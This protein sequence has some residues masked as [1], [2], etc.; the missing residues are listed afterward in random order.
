MFVQPEQ[1]EKELERIDDVMNGEDINI[2]EKELRVPIKYERIRQENDKFKAEIDM[3]RFLAEEHRNKLVQV[4][5][6]K[7]DLSEDLQDLQNVINNKNEQCECYKEDKE[8]ELQATKVRQTNEI[9]PL[10]QTVKTN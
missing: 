2:N 8:K 4:E 10:E 5:A 7:K 3:L 6:E 9:K 1:E